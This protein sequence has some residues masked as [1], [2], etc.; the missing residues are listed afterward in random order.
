MASKLAAASD[1]Q[2][3]QMCTPGPENN[4][5]G[6]SSDERPQNEHRVEGLEGDFLSEPARSAGGITPPSNGGDGQAGVKLRSALAQLL[7]TP[8]VQQT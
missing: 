2:A 8:R 4:P 1:V 6:R 3:L 7:H 5:S